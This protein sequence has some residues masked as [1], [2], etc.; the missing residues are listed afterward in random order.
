SFVA[1]SAIS[2]STQTAS[3]GNG[4]ASDGV[5]SEAFVRSTP[6]AAGLAVASTADDAAA[7]GAVGAAFATSAAPCGSSGG[8]SL[9]ANDH[10]PAAASNRAKQATIAARAMTAPPRGAGMLAARRE[11]R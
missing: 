5:S 9:I 3:A 8:P 2:T 7:A 6:A 10:Q 11:S 1:L 4:G